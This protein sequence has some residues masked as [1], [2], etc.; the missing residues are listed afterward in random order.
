M[1]CHCPA[2]GRPRFSQV[3]HGAGRILEEETQ[4]PRVR[5]PQVLVCAICGVSTMGWRASASRTAHRTSPV[6]LP[7]PR[8]SA[9]AELRSSAVAQVSI[10]P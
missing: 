1:D 4:H 2:P 7:D 8:V 3:A 5:S 6:R 9:A 10:S